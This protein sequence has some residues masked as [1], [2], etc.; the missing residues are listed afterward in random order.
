VQRGDV[1]VGVEPHQ[2]LAALG[3]VARAEVDAAHEPGHLGRD[4]DATHCAHAP[5][6]A[7]LRLPV[8]VVHDGSGH[9]LRRLGI[10]RHE[11]LDHDPFEYIEAH[12]QHEQ[13]ADR[14]HDDEQ[15]PAPEFDGG[16]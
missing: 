11:L 15:P 7:D 5:D 8:R 2:Y 12:Q 1:R 10:P 4:V 6:G 14:G 16:R 13:A 3:I 9:R